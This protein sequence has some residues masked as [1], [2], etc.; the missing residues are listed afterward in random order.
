MTDPKYTPSR[1]SRLRS[2]AAIMPAEG[3]IRTL[4]DADRIPALR[5]VISM[6]ARMCDRIDAERIALIRA[7]D[8]KLR[9]A[10]DTP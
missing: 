6:H 1:A 4:D 2:W 9:A 8:R 3:R 5:T 10:N 7:S